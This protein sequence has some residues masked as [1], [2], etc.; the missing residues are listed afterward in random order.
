MNTLVYQRSQ[1]CPHCRLIYN[2]QYPD[3]QEIIGPRYEACQYCHHPFNC[4]CDPKRAA[5]F[6]ILSL[7]HLPP[8]SFEQYSAQAYQL[9]VSHMQDNTHHLTKQLKQLGDSLNHHRQLLNAMQQF[10]QDKGLLIEF[11]L[12][13]QKKNA[14]T[15][16]NADRFEEQAKK[17][18]ESSKNKPL[19]LGV[20]NPHSDD[21]DIPF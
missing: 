3:H 5:W 18:A 2:T 7:D 9:P 14:E 4:D 13:Q 8:T 15:H 6:S 20:Y 21:E 10:L 11:L 17:H 19:P 16:D 1:Y 12:H